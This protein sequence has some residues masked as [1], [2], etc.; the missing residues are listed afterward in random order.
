MCN[1]LSKL[2]EESAIELL[3]LLF[4]AHK[5]SNTKRGLIE[6]STINLFGWFKQEI[7]YANSIK[8]SDSNPIEQ[9]N[10]AYL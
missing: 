4:V 6:A 1:G 5:P 2:F 3:N 9:S 7:S 8:S 10:K